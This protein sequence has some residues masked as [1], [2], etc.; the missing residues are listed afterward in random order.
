MLSSLLLLYFHTIMPLT[1]PA[2]SAR[3]RFRIKVFPAVYDTACET[4]SLI[5][6][7]GV[8]YLLWLTVNRYEREPA[9]T[10]RAPT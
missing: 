7:P 4:L 3:I 8:R 9:A 1:P 6:E 10:V 5:F 2:A